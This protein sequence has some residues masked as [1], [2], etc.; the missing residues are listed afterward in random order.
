MQ[1][2]QVV[3]PIAL[4]SGATL[5]EPAID[6]G[7]TA[8]SFQAAMGGEPAV[9]MPVTGKGEPSTTTGDSRQ[10]ALKLAMLAAQPIAP[11]AALTDAVGTGEPI[12]VVEDE[13]TFHSNDLESD[14]DPVAAPAS[15]P[16]TNK[17]DV[18][19]GVGQPNNAAYNVGEGDAPARTGTESAHSDPHSPRSAAAIA[20]PVV[21]TIPS[22]RAAQPVSTTART[23]PAAAVWGKE[24][25]QIE[26]PI[27][28]P[29]AMPPEAGISEPRPRHVARQ[30]DAVAPAVDAPDDTPDF[31]PPRTE[32]QK[33]GVFA[34]VLYAGPR[35]G[36]ALQDQGAALVEVFD[37]RSGAPGPRPLAM[38]EQSPHPDRRIDTPAAAPQR[39]E[40]ASVDEV[41]PPP[42]PHRQ[43]AT[44]AAQPPSANATAFVVEAAQPA[45]RMIRL[46]PR[47]PLELDVAALL[48]EQ[49]VGEARHTPDMARAQAPAAP[50]NAADVR[51][52]AVQIANVLTRANERAVELRLHPEELGRVSLT[53]SGE[54][55][56]MTVAVSVERA[57]TLDLM[58]RHIETLGDELRRMGYGSVTFTFADGQGGTGHGRTAASTPQAAAEMP[59][60][61]A[62]LVA[63]AQSASPHGAPGASPGGIDMRV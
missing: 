56:S 34:E 29:I 63:D 31:V 40:R 44:G 33:P 32:A 12:A 10:P 62:A 8:P 57:E 4:D 43:P 41:V 21:E 9:P 49:P 54:G 24:R 25:P 18:P 50:Y 52:V 5:V 30:T 6:A 42:E 7:G 45:Q 17:P 35:S 37:P 59:D 16:D 46:D 13:N 55:A 23:A 1:I 3:T 28:A 39:N 15:V 2:T 38:R 27:R 36:G 47:D 22:E 58:R 61:E 53:L 19:H 60:R 48:R 51:G 20:L 26:A 14:L 11:S